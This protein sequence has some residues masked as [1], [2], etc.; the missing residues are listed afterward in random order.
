MGHG[1]ILQVLSTMSRGF[2][3]I[4]SAMANG[5]GWGTELVHEP[6]ISRIMQRKNR[7]SILTEARGE[8]LQKFAGDEERGGYILFAHR[9]IGMVA[10]A[11]G[12][13]QE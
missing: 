5:N 7:G 1:A 4:S 6:R 8:A 10:D 2:P 13:A 11:A 3:P 9:F 12:A